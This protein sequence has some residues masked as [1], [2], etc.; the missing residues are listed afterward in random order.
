MVL[1]TEQ[2]E[3]LKKLASKPVG[4]M[5]EKQLAK[6]LKLTKKAAKE[7]KA[8]VVSGCPLARDHILQGM[9]RI[10]GKAPEVDSSAHPIQI[11]ARAYG[12]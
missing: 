11:L 9:E 2:R 8:Y 3:K 10:D 5:N 4:E 1:T 12:Y 6:F 7:A